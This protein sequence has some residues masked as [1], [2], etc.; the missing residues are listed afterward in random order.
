ME[1]AQNIIGQI[2]KC[3][4]TG[5][6][7]IAAIDGITTNYATDSDGNIYSDEGVDIAEKQQLL[8]RTKPFYA[9]VST[10]GKRITGWKGNT[11][12]MITRIYQTNAGFGGYRGGGQWYIRATDIN[13]AEWYGRNSGKGCCITLRSCKGK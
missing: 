11:H 3:H 10:D 8:D 2:V 9:Y 4:I 13:G 7:F 1:L 12:M 5:K 6:S